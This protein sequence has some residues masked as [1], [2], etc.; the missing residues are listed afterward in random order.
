M[1]S[2]HLFFRTQLE[3]PDTFLGV[4]GLCCLQKS[5]LVARCL[6]DDFELEDVHAEILLRIDAPKD[7]ECACGVIRYDVSSLLIREHLSKG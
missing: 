6:L 4:S 5:E 7:I 2:T 1:I 3:K